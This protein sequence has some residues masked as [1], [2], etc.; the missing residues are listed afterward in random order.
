M[1]SVDRP[2]RQQLCKELLENSEAQDKKDGNETVTN[3]NQM[4]LRAYD[5]KMRPTDAA[6]T[7]QLFRLIQ[8]HHQ[9]I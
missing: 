4:K 7:E 5:G 6:D 3:C 1:W 8:I 2:A 9:A